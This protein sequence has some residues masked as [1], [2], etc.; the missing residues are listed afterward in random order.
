MK[1][2]LVVSWIVLI[3]ITG[4][5]SLLSI[6]DVESSTILLILF[7][8]LVKFLGVSFY[9]MEMNRSNSFWKVAIL[10]FVTIFLLSAT[11]IL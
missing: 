9:F 6:L 2:H 10:L 11:I 7:L 5:A 4:V 3:V 1:K 8:S